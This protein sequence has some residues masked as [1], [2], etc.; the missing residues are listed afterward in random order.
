[1]IL[2][3]HDKKLILQGNAE[4]SGTAANKL[5]L[6][7]LAP[8]GG[9]GVYVNHNATAKINNCIIK[10]A[11][12]GIYIDND[13]EDLEIKNNTFENCNFGIRLEQNTL[14]TPYIFDNTFTNCN[15]GIFTVSLASVNIGRNNIHASVPIFLVNTA[16]PI[17]TLNQLTPTSLNNGAG[18]YLH[19]C[20]GGMIRKNDI[21][22]FY[23]GIVLAESSP[24]I[25]LNKIIGNNSAGIYI[26]AGS[27]P[28]LTPGYAEEEEN[29]YLI[30][31]G[32]FNYVNNNGNNPTDG[33]E[34]YLNNSNPTFDFG[35]NTIKDDRQTTTLLM[36]GFYDGEGAPLN[37][38]YNYWGM[39]G[40]DPIGRF[41]IPV[42]IYP[43]LTESPA[44]ENTSVYSYLID[45][46]SRP[47]DT[48]FVVEEIYDAL[49]PL[50]NLIALAEEYFYEQSY[51]E[52]LAIYKNV[53]SVYG[54]DGLRYDTYARLYIINMLLR[55]ELPEF[56][57][58]QT[59]Y[60]Q[61]SAQTEDANLAYTLQ[62][63]SSMIDIHSENYEPAIDGFNTIVDSLP[64][65][66]EALFAEMDAVT[67]EYLAGTSGVT[68]GKTSGK[69]K[70]ND[71]E[72]L[73]EFYAQTLSR[74]FKFADKLFNKEVE[75]PKDFTLLQNYPNP[76]NPQT[77]IGYALPKK[78]KVNLAVYDILGRKIITLVDDYK[79]PGSYEVVFDASTYAS[80]VYMYRLTTENYVLSRKMLYLK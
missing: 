46:Y 18:I 36:N 23:N 32:G 64:G 47:I 17:I 34:I 55:S 68:L 6:D 30:D 15:R 58:T 44:F 16:Y 8:T 63:L 7:F 45:S 77:K 51:E 14:G 10:N 19:S 69:L 13:I 4:L 53:T 33:S 28:N 26:G 61:K 56:N 12:A 2:F 29:I 59:L 50:E 79:E 35:R 80:G 48:V 72:S 52:A 42:N 38:R 73:N 54:D 21:N 41:G 78:A 43:F 62:H 70:K 60:E 71:I 22:N 49:S 65:T 67:A 57:Q 1:M 76:F 37:A 31:D 11:A 40:A 39:N 66:E 25:G 20:G 9:K 75:L 5:T 3:H 74:K 24:Q 27:N